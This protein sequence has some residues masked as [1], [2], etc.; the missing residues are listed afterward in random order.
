[1]RTFARST[2]SGSSAAPSSPSS[3]SSRPTAFARAARSTRA[4]SSG[5]PRR[6]SGP[7]AC[8]RSEIGALGLLE[9]VRAVAR[10]LR[11]TPGVPV[12]VDPVMIATRGRSRLLAGS[13]LAAMR[14]RLVPCATVV[15][16]NAPEAA[17][18]TG[19]R[20]RTL[21]EARVAA[22]RL[23]EMGARAALVKGGHLKVRRD[24]VDVLA[25]GD[26][27]V[28]LRSRRIRFPAHPRRR[29]RAGVAHRGAACP[30]RRRSW[31]RWARG[32]RAGGEAHAPARSSP[33]RRRRG[34]DARAR[35]VIVCPA[36]HLAKRW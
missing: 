28:E 8:A 21:A 2:R 27:L 36:H 3:P 6:S 18:L 4:S 30:D 1:M 22:R 23:V 20:V 29:V 32:S 15:T 5:R 31:P 17:A 13:A 10:W 35:A 11:R 7:S 26:D 9:N 16:A 25:V 12:V 24:A 33:C 14:D 19:Q 34:G